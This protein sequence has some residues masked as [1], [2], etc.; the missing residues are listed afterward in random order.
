MRKIKAHELVTLSEAD[1][2]LVVRF[3]QEK[4]APLQIAKKVLLVLGMNGVVWVMHQVIVDLLSDRSDFDSLL[5]IMGYIQGALF[6]FAMV[7]TA[8]CAFKIFQSL[9]ELKSISHELNE[10]DLDVSGLTEDEVWEHAA[11]PLFRKTLRKSGIEIT[12]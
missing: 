9:Q 3:F 8:M 2:I 6:L 7:I 1:R 10:R 4:N 12:D 5:N 11:L